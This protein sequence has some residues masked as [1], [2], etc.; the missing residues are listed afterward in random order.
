MV[1]LAV[2]VLCCAV[3][4]WARAEAG[5]RVARAAPATVAVTSAD[6]PDLEVPAPAETL[7]EPEDSPRADAPRPQNAAEDELRQ[8]DVRDLVAIGFT[9]E[10]LVLRVEYAAKAKGRVTPRVNILELLGPEGMQLDV[11]RALDEKRR[12]GTR[13]TRSRTSSRRSRSGR[14][15]RRA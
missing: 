10:E 15:F 1:R 13:S 2:P 4:L 3:V 12:T 8:H 14:S 7:G 5:R 11:E 6:P 9:I